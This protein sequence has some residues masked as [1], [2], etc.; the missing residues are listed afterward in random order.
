MYHFIFKKHFDIL[1]RLC[2]FVDNYMVSNFHQCADTKC[3]RKIKRVNAL[4]LIQYDYVTVLTHMHY[5]VTH[6]DHPEKNYWLISQI[7]A[8]QCL[9]FI[10]YLKLCYFLRFR[11]HIYKQYLFNI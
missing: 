11:K 3:N 4:V 7:N 2:Q 10:N 9:F 8:V 5:T 1:V 6:E